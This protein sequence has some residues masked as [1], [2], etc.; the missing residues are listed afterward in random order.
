[1]KWAQIKRE[2]G[3]GDDTDYLAPHAGLCLHPSPTT[4]RVV[5]LKAAWS[6]L[7]SKPGPLNSVLW[8]K[9]GADQNTLPAIQQVFSMKDLLGF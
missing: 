9:Y 1:M 4:N 8:I 3:P 5:D 7:S 6:I 2:G